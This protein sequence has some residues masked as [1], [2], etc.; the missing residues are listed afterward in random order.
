[1][2]N[3]IIDRPQWQTTKQRVVFGSVTILFW[4]LWIYLWLPIL[5]FVGWL[6]GLKLAYYQMV[7][8]NGYVGLLHLMAIYGLVVLL[9][10]G[11]L[12]AWAYYNYFRFRGIERRNARPVVKPVDVG[13]RYG[14]R[15]DV[16][17]QWTQSRRL[18]LHHS[19]DRQ[20][21]DGEAY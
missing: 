11:G 17:E 13:A 7:E 21:I 14:V 10:G 3:L 12:L 16:L 19:N 6:L 1:M 4:A 15:A 9:L 20:L 8:L 18:V 5:G 2:K